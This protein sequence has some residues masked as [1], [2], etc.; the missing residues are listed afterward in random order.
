MNLAELQRKGAC[1]DRSPVRR[2]ITWTHTDEAGHET[3][4]TFDV[5]VLRLSFGVIDRLSKTDDDAE[6]SR[7][8]ELIAASIRLGEKAEEAIPYDV[9]YSLQMSLALELVRAIGEV[10]R[11]KPEEDSGVPKD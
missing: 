4:D 2:S 10:N 1:V 11:L 7:N 3:T 9:A 6:R 5:W 8:A